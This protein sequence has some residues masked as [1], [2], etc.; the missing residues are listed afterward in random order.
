MRLLLSW[1]LS[2]IASQVLVGSK[3]TPEGV[4]EEDLPRP[5]VAQDQ[6]FLRL[7]RPKE[8][9]AGGWGDTQWVRTLLYTFEGLSSGPSSQAKSS[10]RLCP[11]L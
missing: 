8:R 9:G 6:F 11:C 2:C 10:V 3:A 7:F 4:V 1:I 5:S